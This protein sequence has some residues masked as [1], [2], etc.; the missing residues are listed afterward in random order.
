[1]DECGIA[2]FDETTI[3]YYE[4]L[5]KHLGSASRYQLLGSLFANN[6]IKGMN[7]LIPAIQGKMGGYTYYGLSVFNLKFCLKLYM[8]STEVKQ[9]MQ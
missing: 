2:Y 4:E 1:M 9:M 8:F 6:T 7:N 5:V 3:K